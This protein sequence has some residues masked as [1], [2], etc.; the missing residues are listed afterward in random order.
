MNHNSFERSNEQKDLF[1]KVEQMDRI[2]EFVQVAKEIL[3]EENIQTIILFDRNPLELTIY[4]LIMIFM[5]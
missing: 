4:G 1:P 2:K 3:G 5:L